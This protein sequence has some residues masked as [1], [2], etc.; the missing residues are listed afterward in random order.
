M[1]HLAKG[2]HRQLD[3]LSETLLS[4]ALANT[5]FMFVPSPKASFP[6]KMHFVVLSRHK[7]KKKKICYALRSADSLVSDLKR[8]PT[9]AASGIRIKN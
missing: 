6:N 8:I 2:E 3:A 4:G 5:V 1:I 7:K 9:H